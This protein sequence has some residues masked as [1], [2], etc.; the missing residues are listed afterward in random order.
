MSLHGKYTE[1]AHLL[2]SFNLLSEVNFNHWKNFNGTSNFTKASILLQM[3]G[4]DIDD[5]TKFKKFR[6]LLKNYS[7]L[8]AIYVNWNKIGL[9]KI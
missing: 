6:A 9:L 3:L 2:Y 4:Y 1:I 5:S 8:Y 7:E